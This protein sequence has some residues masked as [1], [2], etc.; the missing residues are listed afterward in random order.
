MREDQTSNQE[1]IA[2]QERVKGVAISVSHVSDSVDRFLRNFLH[3]EGV[4]IGVKKLED[5]WIAN[6]EVVEEKRPFD[7]V[8][9]TYEITLDE[10]SNVM[11]FERRV[12][13]KRSELSRAEPSAN[14]LST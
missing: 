9:A 8:V 13:R 7:D 2:S 10:K 6:V 11:N 12:V 3:R 1:G 14:V 5:S 4:L